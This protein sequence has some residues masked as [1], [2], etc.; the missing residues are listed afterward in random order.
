MFSLPVESKKIKTVK[1]DGD[2][3]TCVTAYLSFIR[4]TLTNNPTIL[5]SLSILSATTL[6]S[7]HTGKQYLFQP[8][9][10]HTR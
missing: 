1:C 6:N 5:N 9:C 7:L 3:T 4:E 8:L 2:I 10:K